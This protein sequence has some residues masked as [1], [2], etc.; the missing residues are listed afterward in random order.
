MNRIVLASGRIGRRQVAA[1]RRNRVALPT[2]SRQLVRMRLAPA[3]L[4]VVVALPSIATA[5]SGVSFDVGYLHSRVA[6]ADATT[7]SGGV[8]RLE[9]ASGGSATSMRVRKRRKAGCQARRRCP[10]APSPEP[11]A[12]QRA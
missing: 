1:L 11:Q 10:T 2:A 9:L 12:H 7:I 3:L 8:A 6:V 5:D 4:L